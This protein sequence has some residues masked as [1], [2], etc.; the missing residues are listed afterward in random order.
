MTRTSAIATDPRSDEELLTCAASDPAAWVPLYWRHV[1]AM[2]R[3]AAARTNTVEEAHDLAAAIWL[4]VL[5]S[6]NRFDASRGPVQHWMFGIASNLAASTFRRRARER[7]ALRRLQGRRALDDDDHARLE[8]R[9]AAA[10]LSRRL[11]EILD[12]LTT[13]QRVVIDLITVGGLTQGEAARTLGVQ[14]HVI[15]NRL[16]RARRKIRSSAPADLAGEIDALINT[17]QEP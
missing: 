17:E 2:L 3:Y 15:R 5:G 13:G 12:R 14:P 10:G 7:E 1:D 9:L 11:G 4:E 6:A 8:A 16:A